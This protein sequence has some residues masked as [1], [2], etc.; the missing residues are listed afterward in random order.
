MA[1]LLAGT[2]QDEALVATEEAPTDERGERTEVWISPSSSGSHRMSAG[3]LWGL[4]AKNEYFKPRSSAFDL[5][6]RNVN[7]N[8][9]IITI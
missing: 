8:Y 1:L 2:E 4:Q 6:D 3:T 7:H 5:D 9:T